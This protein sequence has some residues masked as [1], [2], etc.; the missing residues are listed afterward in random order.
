[1]K[2]MIALNHLRRTSSELT[3]SNQKA[4]YAATQSLDAIVKIECKRHPHRRIA[5]VN[6]DHLEQA[7]YNLIENRSS[8]AFSM[9]KMH[10]AKWLATLA[11]IL[12]AIA[13]KAKRQFNHT[14]NH[15]CTS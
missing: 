11:S 9:L 1:M 6:H 8:S 14:S 15:H 10:L 13:S 12:W 7:I 5:V 4:L 3:T 2:S